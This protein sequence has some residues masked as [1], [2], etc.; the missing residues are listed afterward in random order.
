MNKKERQKKFA[1]IMQYTAKSLK[2]LYD[3]CPL[4]P[5]FN[6]TLNSDAL[7]RIWSKCILCNPPFE[8][9]PLFLI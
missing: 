7:D 5:N 9:A 6:I 8:K 3:I 1:R 2:D 4:D